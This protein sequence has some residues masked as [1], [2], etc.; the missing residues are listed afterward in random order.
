MRALTRL[1]PQIRLACP[2]CY[3]RFFRWEIMFRC[4]GRAN[5]A[6]NQ[7]DA[8]EDPVYTAHFGPAFQ[9]PVFPSWRPF[10]AACPT[11]TVETSVRVCP[12][13]HHRLPTRFA[14]E[15]SRLIA[16]VGARAS[17][18]T[19]MLTVLMHELN[20]RSGERFGSG[21]WGADEETQ[22]RFSSEYERTLY[23]NFE[24]LQGTTSASVE[25][26]GLRAPLVFSFAA[27]R[28]GPL[29]AAHAAVVLRHRR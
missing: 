18:K 11:C 1:V 9:L 7:C 8:A 19:V 14:R 28:G 29:G 17:G 2:Y 3:D 27:Q 21:A 4:A 13:C 26:A 12:R 24:L 10:K 20:G 15:P 6:G 22:R 23:D 5:R 25:T 16:L